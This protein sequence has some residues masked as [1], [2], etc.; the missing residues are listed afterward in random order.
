LKDKFIRPGRK[1]QRTGLVG[2]LTFESANSRLGGS[3]SKRLVNL[4]ILARHSLARE[5]AFEFSTNLCP[6]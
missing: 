3:S 2:F 6:I 5:A 4:Q 1:F